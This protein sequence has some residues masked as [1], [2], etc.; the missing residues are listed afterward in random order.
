MGAPDVLAR[1]AAA[2]IKLTPLPDGR[3]LAQPSAL[4]ND[5][6][7]ELI[8]SHLAELLASLS[9]EP[10]GEPDATIDLQFDHAA[11]ARRE[12]VL[13]MLEAHPGARYAFLTDTRAD[14]EVVIVALAIRGQVTC[15][16][17]IPRKKWDGV[18]FL[19]FLE[20]HAVH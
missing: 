8:R 9:M 11:E 14:P 2:G 10:G 18:L 20:R 1:L 17:R 5:E 3:L 12:R 15:E 13:A 4:L 16:L 7:R 6:L 19:E